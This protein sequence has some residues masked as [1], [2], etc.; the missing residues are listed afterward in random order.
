[1]S[2]ARERTFGETLNTW[3]KSSGLSFVDDK[4]G[5]QQAQSVSEL[6]LWD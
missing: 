2:D 4:L 1:M 5:L 3:C 6:S